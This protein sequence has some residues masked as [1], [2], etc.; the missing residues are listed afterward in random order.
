[1]SVQ[2]TIL[3]SREAWLEHRRKFIG[4]SDS[5]AIV[6]A[7]PHMSNVDLWEIKTGRKVQKDISEEPFVKYG[8]E[9]ERYLRELYKLDFPEYKVEYIENNSWHNDL[10]PWAAVSLDGWLTDQDGR[11]GVWE[12]KT[13]NILRA[14]QKSEWDDRIP[15]GYYVQILHEL[16]VTGFEFAIMTAQLRYRAG[17]DMFKVT[18]HYRVEQ[19][20]VEPDIDYL[21]NAERRF[22]DDVISDK[23]PALKLPDL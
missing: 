13:T 8:S 14:G 11:R 9:A 15:N 19:A 18:R 21:I 12:C 17:D 23:R 16:M 4:G 22:W 5:A 20:E 6:N 7:S 2:M 10:Y 3:G 1:M